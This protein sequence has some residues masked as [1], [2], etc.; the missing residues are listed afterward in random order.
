VARTAPRR[1]PRSATASARGGRSPA[2]T[3][4]TGRVPP[5]H[6]ARPGSARGRGVRAGAAAR[7]C[8][9]PGH[10]R[11]RAAILLGSN[12]AYVNL[13]RKSADI[14]AS[15]PG[16]SP[17]GRTQATHRYLTGD[18]RM[19][20][21]PHEQSSPRGHEERQ[22]QGQH[23]S[24]GQAS[25]NG[26]RLPADREQA[27]ALRREWATDP[28]WSGIERTYSAADV[29]KLRGSVQEEH[30]L[31][32]IGRRAAVVTA[33]A[34]SLRQ[35]ARR[36]DRQPGGAAGQG[37]AEG[38]LP[39]RL[40]GRGGRQPGRPD[41]PGPEP[42]PG[43]LGAAGRPPDQ[44][45]AAARRPDHLGETAAA[46]GEQPHWLAPIVADAEAGFGGVL[47]AFELMKSMIAA[48]ACGRALGGPARIREEVRPPRRQGADPD[49]PHPQDAERGPPR[50][51][52]LR[53]PTALSSPAPT[54]SR[55]A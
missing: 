29:V 2:A 30:T 26:Q 33:A 1:A 10:L 40:A 24:N 55:R 48:G 5:G 41:V 46:T 23:C 12:L 15:N 21:G 4:R 42:V 54:R 16:D 37:R 45:R 25:T 36:A 7:T 35:R 19:A 43:Q 14:H 52:H 3:A 34:R 38:H 44:Q 20:G 9:R 51:R 47:N 27:A 32:R 28:R 39:V 11:S 50:R 6:R 53:R 8:R 22:R 13:R 18:D 49:R 17:A 31:A